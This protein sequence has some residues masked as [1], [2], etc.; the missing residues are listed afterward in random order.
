MAVSL[1]HLNACKATKNVIVFAQLQPGKG[2]EMSDS[3]EYGGSKNPM[4]VAAWV[5]LVAAVVW[6]IIATAMA[7][8]RGGELE[9][10]KRQLADARVQAEQLSA[11]I[12]ANKADLDRRIQETEQIRKTALD[13]TRQAQLRIQEIEKQKAA[14]KQAAASTAKKGTTTTS[15]KSSATTKKSSSSG[16]TTPSKK[17][18]R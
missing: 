14:A 16:K 1:L 7:F 18:T 5:M 17:S 15:S 6:A 8:K 11:S 4:M 2:V 13:W 10:A 9:L 3:Q 12:E